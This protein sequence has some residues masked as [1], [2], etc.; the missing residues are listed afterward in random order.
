MS[1][2]SSVSKV[3]EYKLGRWYIVSGGN[4][5][6]SFFHSMRLVSHKELFSGVKQQE[7]DAPSLCSS[8]ALMLNRCPQYA[9]MVFF[10]T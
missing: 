5:Q 3:T 10:V 6:I 4:I 7:H 8:G 1:S 2:E 9:N